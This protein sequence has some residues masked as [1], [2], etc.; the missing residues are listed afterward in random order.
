MSLETTL[1]P[2]ISSLPIIGGAIWGIYTKISNEIKN[3]FESQ[4]IEFNTKLAEERTQ[5]EIEKK[6]LLTKINSM[7]Y[8]INDIL[9]GSIISGIPI[10]IKVPY[11]LE[12]LHVNNAFIEQIAIPANL[13]LEDLIGKKYN[14]LFP[15]LYLKVKKAHEILKKSRLAEIQNI[16]LNDCKYRVVVEYVEFKGERAFKDSFYLLSDDII[17][18]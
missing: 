10:V 13:R 5:C 15:E 9:V 8:V 7:Q 3:K 14:E 17:I 1:I 6:E 12:I 16:E 18:N 4:R 2:I 11:T